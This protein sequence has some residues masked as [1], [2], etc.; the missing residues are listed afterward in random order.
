MTRWLSIVCFALS[1]VGFALTTYVFSDWNQAP[2][3]LPLPGP[4]Y[5]VA[6]PFHLATGG[7][8]ELR[9]SV[10]VMVA[11]REVGT[12]PSPPP[13]PT[14]LRLVIEQGEITKV[15][16]PIVEMGHMGR[17]VFGKVDSYVARPVVTLPRGDYVIRLTGL[18]NAVAP[19]G[20]AML[21]LERAGDPTTAVLLSGL[22]RMASACAFVLGLGLL[23]WRAWRGKEG[24]P[25]RV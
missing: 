15:D 19:R 22:T 14:N 24:A 2:A 4:G 12:P 3:D 6:E 5:S 11:D 20:G 10:P 13:I 16:M 18:G 1:A 25:A 23:P 21:S 7:K 8:F 9:A 17:Y